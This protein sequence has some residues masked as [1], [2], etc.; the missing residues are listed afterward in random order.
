MCSGRRAVAIC[1]RVAEPAASYP[2]GTSDRPE[3]ELA[4]WREIC[5]FE[6][7]CMHVRTYVRTYVCMYVC[8]G[9]P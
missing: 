8:I 9:D 3:K 5:R 2:A 7:V 1:G 6:Y 4:R